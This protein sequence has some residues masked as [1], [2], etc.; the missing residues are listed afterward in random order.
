ML[1]IIPTER[2]YT[3]RSL[4]DGQSIFYEIFDT[5]GEVIRIIIFSCICK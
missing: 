3:H 2:L 5:A 4:V 1:L